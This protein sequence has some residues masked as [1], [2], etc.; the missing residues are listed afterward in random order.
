MAMGFNKNH[1]YGRSR[2][3]LRCFLTAFAI[4]TLFLLSISRKNNSTRA[5]FSLK[6]ECARRLGNCSISYHLLHSI[7]R[8]KLGF[9]KRERERCACAFGSSVTRAEY[10]GRRVES[11][12]LIRLSLFALRSRAVARVSSGVFRVEWRRLLSPV[13]A[14]WL[15]PETIRGREPSD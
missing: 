4:R 7:P 12:E 13:S 15:Q 14:P 11:A 3:R 5:N 8:T 9:R 2:A 6:W 1:G 10:P